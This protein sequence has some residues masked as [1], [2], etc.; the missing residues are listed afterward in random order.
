MRQG[1]TVR[2]LAGLLIIL[3]TSST[4]ILAHGGEDHGDKPAQT[5]AST[6]GT[7]THTKRIDDIE[8]TLKHPELVPDTASSG[9]LFLTQFQTNGPLDGA[10]A[11]IEFEGTDGS[12]VHTVVAKTDEPGIFTVSVPA[13]T[14]GAYVIRATITTK[15]QTDTATFSGVEVRSAATG[16]TGSLYGW[17][18]SLLVGVVFLLLASLFIALIYLIMR[19]SASQEIEGEALSA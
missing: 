8:V 10:T 16:I 4:S 12:V 3:F 7:I 19:T 13:L 1:T 14:Q 11:V 2:L 17:A 15:G 18:R 6:K 5:T 9:K